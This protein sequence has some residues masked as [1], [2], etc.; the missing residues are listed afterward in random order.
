MRPAQNLRRPISDLGLVVYRWIKCLEKARLLLFRRSRYIPQSYEQVGVV[1][2]EGK[3][4][5]SRI[6]DVQQMMYGEA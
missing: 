1:T 4:R 3:Y 2:C 6:A 5:H